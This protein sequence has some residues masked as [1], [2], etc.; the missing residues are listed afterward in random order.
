MQSFDVSKGARVR[1]GYQAAND[2]LLLEAP[3]RSSIQ[4][5]N[6]SKRV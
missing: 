6:I 4:S 3:H 2:L 1:I 5:L